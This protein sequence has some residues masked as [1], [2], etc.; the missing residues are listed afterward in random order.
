MQEMD[1]ENLERLIIEQGILAC[2]TYEAD[3]K[4]MCRFNAIYPA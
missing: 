2:M 4:D 1:Y 3:K